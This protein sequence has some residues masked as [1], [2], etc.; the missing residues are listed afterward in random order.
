MTMTT[1]TA[2]TLP[3]LRVTEIG[4]YIRHSSCER[5]FR[6]EI[7]RRR[8]ARSLPFAERLFNALDPVLQVAGRERE[9][10]WEAA[11]LADGLRDLSNYVNRPDDAKHTPWHELAEEL[12]TLAEGADAYGREVEVSASLGTF[13]VQGR[14]DFVLL[15]WRD[16]R[17]RLRLVEC[18]ASRRDRT[19]L[20]L[21]NTLQPEKASIV[22]ELQTG[23]RWRERPGVKCQA[24]RGDLTSDSAGSAGSGCWTVA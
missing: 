9:A 1:S 23:G 19:Y 13:T 22:A 10:D 6:L 11:L 16:G 21:S 4:E 15:L 5:R 12:Q 8:L 7:N 14:I 17:P 2:S 24:R 18:K 20:R 3:T